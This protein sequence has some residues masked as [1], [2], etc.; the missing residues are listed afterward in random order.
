MIG[1][2]DEPEVG[3]SSVECPSADATTSG[4]ITESSGAHDVGMENA[5]VPGTCFIWELMCGGAATV[6]I[7]AAPARST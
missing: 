3:E 6:G 2:I 1:D 7:F 5:E 4:D